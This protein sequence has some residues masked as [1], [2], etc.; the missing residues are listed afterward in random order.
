V[1][2]ASLHTHMNA[3]VDLAIN[4][5]GNRV[6]EIFPLGR[7]LMTELDEICILYGDLKQ[8]RH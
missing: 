8:S 5:Y 7:Y 2:P 6:A 1:C 3:F 4:V